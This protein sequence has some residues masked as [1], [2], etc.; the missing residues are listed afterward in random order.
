[1]N[2]PLN[3]S[4]KPRKRT[5]AA[6]LVA[7]GVL[8]VWLVAGSDIIST[9]NPTLGRELALAEHPPLDVWIAPPGTA[10]ISPTIIST[11]AGVRFS[12]NTLTIPQGST[13]SAHLAEQDGNA[14][15]LV[16]DDNSTAFTADAHGDFQATASLTSGKK[17]SIRR[18]WLTLASWKINVVADNPPKIAITEPPI[19]TNEKSLRLAYSASD[20]FGVSEVALRIT[21]RDPLPG[22]TN[23][24]VDIT[25]PIAPAPQ[26]MHVI[27]ANLNAYPWAGQNVTLQLIA[28]NEAGKT[29]ESSTAD[30]TLPERTFEHP[31]SRILIEERKKLLLHPEDEKLREETA[32]ILAEIAHETNNYH[33]DPVVLMT[34]RSGAVRLVLNND[35][36]TVPAVGDMLWQAATRIED[37]YTAATQ[38]ML[39]EDSGKNSA[40]LSNAPKDKSKANP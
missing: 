12:H 19:L 11:P 30:L 27:Y 34:L 38:G 7:V 10:N 13:V 39:N 4:I 14:P 23:K 17:L 40:N 29:S 3:I 37:G 16:I 25:L 21:P 32:G 22:A 36:S 24:S 5:I 6:V 28:T 35:S 18:G 31:V 33:S 20:E 8:S 15:E 26:M 2:R 1:M 9:L